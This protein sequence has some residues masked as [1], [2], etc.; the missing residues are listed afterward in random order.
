MP[1]YLQGWAATYKLLSRNFKSCLLYPKQ[2]PLQSHSILPDKPPS[3]GVL[4]QDFSLVVFC[5][6][7]DSSVVNK[8]SSVLW[9]LILKYPHH[10]GLVDCHRVGCSL[11]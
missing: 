8:G 7:F 3:V 6:S 5:W 9:D 10:L 4:L 2:D 11:G 1:Y